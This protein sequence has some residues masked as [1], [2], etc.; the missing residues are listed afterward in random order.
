MRPF[1]AA[2]MACLVVSLA[3]AS[4]L[5]A[6]DRPVAGTGVAGAGVAGTVVAGTVVAGTVVDASG[7]AV[8]GAEVIL[9]IGATERRTRTDAVGF[10]AFEGVAPGPA[11]V[12]VAFD[13]F[14]PVTVDVDARRTELRVVLTPLP[15]TEQVTVHA[16]FPA[17]GRITSAT[18][19]D[20][21][22]R[23]VPQSIS[24]VTG[25]LIADQS[26]RSMGDV[27]RYV[28]GV[29]IAQG[30][31]NRDTPVFR[32]NSSTSDFYVDGVRDDVQYFR[33]LYN[34]DRVEA[35]KGPNA[36]VFGRGGVGG[37]INRVL[38]LADWSSAGE[39][40]VQ[41][42]SWDE[43]RITGDLARAVSDTLAIRVTGMF[44]NS[45]SYRDFVGNQRYGVNPSVAFM[46][47]ANTTLKTSYEHFHDDR[48]ADRGIS[49]FQGA[50][51]VTAP[52]T[53]FGNP[54]LSRSDV[55]VNVASA[56]LEHRLNDA[57]TVR[58]RASFGNYDKFYQN[59]FPGAVNAAGTTV[60]IS[61]YNQGTARQNLFSQTDLIVT[62]RTGRVGHTVLAGLE[63][64]RQE[65]DNLRRTGY[66][67]TIGPA[68]TSISVPLANPTTSLP[69]EFRP[70]AT[71]A[72]NSGVAGV[73]ALYAQDQI[74]LSEHV[75][76]VVG[77]RYDNFSVDFHNNRT[78][79]TLS[80]TDNL[81]SPR[82]G[83]I[84]KPVEPM[85]VYASY[86]LAY[87]PRA[88]E[89]L[90]S[91]SLTN[92]ALEPEEFRN[93]EVGAK[94]DLGRALS[95]T[96]AVYRLDRGNVAVADPLDPTVLVLVDGQR[97]SG[98]EL[99]VSGSITP[100]WSMIGGYALQDGEITSSLSAS[101]QAGARLA[102]LPKH[103]FSL[104]NRYDVSDRFGVGLGLIHRGEIFTSTDNSVVLPSFTRLDAALFASLTA[105]LRAQLN[106]ENL[107]DRQYYASAHSNTNITPGSPR[108]VRVALTTRF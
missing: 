39:L 68:V 32:G 87:L 38:R 51:V 107:F 66:F 65:T 55:T 76:A 12:T 82:V 84:V 5:L 35:L 77:V 89:Q 48:T 80:S 6:Q 56:V 98:V 90:S 22:L 28:P 108:R 19:T 67:T 37:V 101:A 86:S 24:I 42:G 3:L 23:D 81:V 27:V 4:S 44:E 88:G 63:L 10:F 93:Y 54:E 8:N 97:S 73:V 9:R 96:L 15:L 78:A 53:F 70:S 52:S 59:V 105:R 69:V 47:G 94:W 11:T 33:D 43:R 74:A 49:S 16:T 14:A 100:A 26:M 95:A 2:A 31:G 57:L 79:T 25:Q 75:Q 46:L 20:T 34:V 61:G 41:G 85:S 1:A 72:D 13:Q 83:L 102:Q 58:S 106:V 50:P 30:E 71:D 29:G 104:W 7:G 99:G 92:Q 17:A 60:A 103:S 18:R 36:M 21:P 62:R 91:L 64:G 45:E 40:A